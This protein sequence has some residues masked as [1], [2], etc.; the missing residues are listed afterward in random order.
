MTSSE[1]AQLLHC[2]QTNSALRT[3]MAEHEAMA[4]EL[5][6]L[7]AEVEQMRPIYVAAIDWHET[8]NDCNWQQLA[9]LERACKEAK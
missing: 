7:R 5:V 9:K 4:A 8:P 1:H 2:A 6:K 3:L